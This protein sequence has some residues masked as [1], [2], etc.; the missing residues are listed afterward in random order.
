MAT[1]SSQA[2]SPDTAL[3]KDDL[4]ALHDALYPA[5]NNYESF[6]L[7]IGVGIDEINSIETQHTDPGKRLLGV[8]SARLR[9]AKTLTWNDIDRALRRECVGESTTADEIRKALFG[10]DPSTIEGSSA[11]EGKEPMKEKSQ[12]KNERKEECSMYGPSLY[13]SDKQEEEEKV[14]EE[15]VII[16]ETK[17]KRS[18]IRIKEYIKGK[19]LD[20]ESE[21]HEREVNKS[22]KD[23]ALK[24]QKSPE[25]AKIKTNNEIVSLPYDFQGEQDKS[26]Y[27]E[28]QKS[29]ERERGEIVQKEAQGYSINEG[30]TVAIDE[31]KQYCYEEVRERSVL[32]SK[33][34]E[35]DSE[36]EYFSCQE[37][38][39]EVIR[40]PTKKHKKPIITHTEEEHQKMPANR[41]R[42]YKWP[43]QKME[44][45]PCQVK[46]KD[47]KGKKTVQVIDEK[48]ATPMGSLV[49]THSKQRGRRSDRERAGME[50]SAAVVENASE[51]T[52]ED[53][54]IS[55]S[56]DGSEDEE[57]RDSKGE[58]L[59]EEEE[60]EGDAKSGKAISG[61]D[62]NQEGHDSKLKKKKRKR[63]RES[64]MSPTD[65]GNSSP[66]TSQEDSQNQP[67]PKGKGTKEGK[68]K[69]TK[70]HKQPLSLT[71]SEIDSS[72]PECD[73]GNGLSETEKKKLS[74]IFSRFFGKLCCAIVNPVEIA[75]QLQEKCLISKAT[76]IEILKSPESQ[77]DKTIGLVSKLNK[78][79]DS[80]PDRL[81]DFIQVLLQSDVLQNEVLQRAGKEMLKEAGK[82]PTNYLC[83]SNTETFLYY[84][85]R[86]SQKSSFKIPKSTTA[87]H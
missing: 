18:V 28:T 46:E 12:G 75:A 25:G 34:V 63:Q 27:K 81:F 51:S 30:T 82:Q 83:V 48:A 65:R 73:I 60:R 1:G 45:I 84:R 49:K 23:N 13:L 55:N 80:R 57:D 33:E 56:D 37:E 47:K 77:Q 52:Q 17:G 15:R 24:N 36:D 19:S 5:R 64:S 62:R 44:D 3:S 14:Y 22:E 26:E 7:Q 61:R 66:S 76:M 38:L 86:M 9:K 78:K 8:L 69:S 41:R 43:P 4:G 70:R 53:S 16:K 87:F 32:K 6:G 31:Q 2:P 20:T 54:E 39:I 68:R 72:S 29:E 59:N 85:Q 79:I 71:S 35:Y 58:S 11:Q 40:K 42:K 10:P 50:K 74:G 67:R 21:P